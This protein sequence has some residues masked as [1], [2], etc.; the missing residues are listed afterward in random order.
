M[1]P[2][3]LE[4]FIINATA[5]RHFANPGMTQFRE[6]MQKIDGHFGSVRAIPQYDQLEKATRPH[7][8]ILCQREASPQQ[9]GPAALFVINA[10]QAFVQKNDL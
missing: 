3:L 10:V 7:L 1:E 6:I 9:T 5:E 8:G 2:S 4:T